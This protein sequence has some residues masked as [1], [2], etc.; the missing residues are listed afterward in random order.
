VRT[1]AA[2]LK[3]AGAAPEEIV[4]RLLELGLEPEPAVRVVHALFPAVVKKGKR[5]R[6]RRET[7]A[8]ADEAGAL[9]KAYRKGL[10]ESRDWGSAP[11]APTRGRPC[12]HCSTLVASGYGQTRVKSETELAGAVAQSRTVMLFLCPECAAGYDRTGAGLLRGLLVAVLG[13]IFLGCGGWLLS[14]LRRP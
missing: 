12:D 2:A 1:C 7:D 14:L 13:L 11:A 4:Q 5:H 3:A 8:V 9:E 6:R 10:R